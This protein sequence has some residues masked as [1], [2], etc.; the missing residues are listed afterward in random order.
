MANI[1]SYL[2]AFAVGSN[3]AGITGKAADGFKAGGYSAFIE[4]ITGSPAQVEQLESNRVKLYL[5]ENQI[6][7]M[8]KWLDNQVGSA[9]QKKEPGSVQYE[10]GPVLK[11]WAFKYTVPA[12]AALFLAGWLVHWYLS[13]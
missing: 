13:R 2:S 12:G 10:L 9:L 11:P 4:S 7:E 3:V 8:Q 6:F 5:N 1:D